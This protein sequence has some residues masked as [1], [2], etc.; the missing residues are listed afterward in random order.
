MS[1]FKPLYVS[2]NCTREDDKDKGDDDGEKQ[3]EKEIRSRNPKV[4]LHS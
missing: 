4:C 1:H 2:I 3:E